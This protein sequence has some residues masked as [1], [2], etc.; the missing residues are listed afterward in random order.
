MT[1]ENN[2]RS[3]KLE[4]IG[5]GA[6]KAINS[7]GG[8][9][10]ML[11]TPEAFSPVELLLAGVAGCSAVDVDIF[12]TRRSDPTEFEVT[13]S[14][15]KVSEGGNRLED[16][17]VVFHVRFPAGEAGDAAR[18]ILTKSITN[19]R[20]RLCTVSRTVQLPTQVTYFEDDAKLD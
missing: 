5:A 13:A 19:S 16:V 14:G 12:T 11:D 17:E 10:T 1:N 2:R 7:R 9:I 3:V 4:R 20:D 6:F 18:E 15:E 8:E